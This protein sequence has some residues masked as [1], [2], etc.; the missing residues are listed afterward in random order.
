MSDRR[1]GKSHAVSPG[2]LTPPRNKFIRRTECY[3]VLDYRGGFP[4]A[5]EQGWG[6]LLAIAAAERRCGTGK[7]MVREIVDVLGSW[8]VED[9]DLDALVERAGRMPRIGRGLGKLMGLTETERAECRAWRLQSVDGPDAAERRQTDGADGRRKR[10]KAERTK[11]GRLTRAAEDARK[12][13]ANAGSER[14]AKPWAALGMSRSTWQ[15]RGKPMPGPG[16]YGPGKRRRRNASQPRAM[17][18]TAA[19]ARADIGHDARSPVATPISSAAIR[20]VT[21]MDRGHRPGHF[22]PGAQTTYPRAIPSLLG[23]PV[24]SPAP[25]GSVHPLTG[26]HAVTVPSRTVA[27]LWTPDTLATLEALFATRRAA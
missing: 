9:E 6:T 14:Q 24:T 18:C 3:R 12:H 2:R 26:Q 19:R 25:A 20:Q 22:R 16:K 8:F 7:A 17:F 4:T 27:R 21:T 15:R 5:D 13:A 23:S 1:L 11:A 10:H